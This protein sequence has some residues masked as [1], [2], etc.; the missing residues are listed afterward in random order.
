V[1]ELAELSQNPLRFNV[2]GRLFHTTYNTIKQSE[3]LTTCS[4]WTPDANGH[5]FIDQPPTTFGHV[6][7]FF[8]LSHWPE[9]LTLAAKAQ[10][11]ELLDYLGIPFLTC[12]LP[13]FQ[14]ARCTPNSNNSF[15]KAPT[16]LLPDA[17]WTNIVKRIGS[18]DFSNCHKIYDSKEGTAPGKFH[19]AVD[20]ARNTL[21]LL[22]LKNGDIIGAVACDYWAAQVR[23]W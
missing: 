21:S 19:T 1:K 7:K 2:G 8:R 5:Y 14:F 3:Y 22:H 6:L 13:S 23:S 4:R 18:Y 17:L 11:E 20:S 15:H 10:M 9:K 12:A 16:P